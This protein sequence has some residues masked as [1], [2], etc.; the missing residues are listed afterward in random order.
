MDFIGPEMIPIFG[1]LMIIA[2]V[3]GPIWINAYFRSRE[4]AQLHETLRKAYEQGQPPPPEL[5]DKLTGES[6]PTNPSSRVDADLRRAVVLIAV[7][8]GLAGLGLG[9]GWG[10]SYASDVGGRVTGGIIAGSGAIP[11]FIGVAYLFLWLLGRQRP[12]A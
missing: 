3:I 9:I 4:R 5:I 10:I 6:A 7:G 8:V 2:I 1:I 11:G 12:H